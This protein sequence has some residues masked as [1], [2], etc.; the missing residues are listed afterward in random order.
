MNRCPRRL[1]ALLAVVAVF[2]ALGHGLPRAAVVPDEEELPAVPG[3]LRP[4]P[5]VQAA[6]ERVVH[7][8]IWL[9]PPS[10]VAGRGASGAEDETRGT[11]WLVGPGQLVTAAHF[12]SMFGGHFTTQPSLERVQLEMTGADG[13]RHPGEPV[14]WRGAADIAVFRLDSVPDGLSPLPLRAT[15]P[16]PQELVWWICRGGLLENEW[17]VGR[18]LGD[19]PPAGALSGRYVNPLHLINPILGGVHPGCSG[20]PILDG[21]GRVIGAVSG[22]QSGGNVLNVLAVRARDIRYA[23]GLD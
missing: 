10:D 20:A 5:A 1:T 9:R 8:E 23:L 18:V 22:F 11:A 15:P 17:S 12:F 4:P 14:M 21:K 19:V 16:R 6:F 13:R 2:A 7:I 3:W